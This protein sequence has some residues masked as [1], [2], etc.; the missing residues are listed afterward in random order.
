MNKKPIM[1]EEE[2]M[3]N[4]MDNQSEEMAESKMEQSKESKK[5]TGKM[6]P[7][8]KARI[9]KLKAYTSGNKNALD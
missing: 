4:G 8:M 6:S 2:E 5:K 9:A 7:A 3:Q 1:S